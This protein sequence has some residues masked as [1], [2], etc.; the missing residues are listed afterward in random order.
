MTTPER[1]RAIAKRCDATFFSHREDA[2]FLRQIAGEIEEQQRGAEE[3]LRAI[4]SATPGEHVYDP[5]LPEKFSRR[6]IFHGMT[7]EQM[8]HLYDYVFDV[9]Q[10]LNPR[11]HRLLVV[12]GV[13]LDQVVLVIS[14]AERDGLCHRS[15]IARY[16]S[17]R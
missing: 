6:S 7:S 15:M 1:L 2:D 13:P 9:D 17:I 8:S 14:Q 5:R 4:D 16:D 10:R 3:L 11:V 12:I